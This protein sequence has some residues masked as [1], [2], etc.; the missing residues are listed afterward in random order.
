MPPGWTPAPERSHTLGL[1]K[2]ATD[3]DYE[4]ARAFC[5]QHPMEAPRLLSSD[6][7]DRV[8][9]EGC[10]VWTMEWPSSP[11]FV[12]HIQDGGEKGA[13]EV[14]KIV[15]DEKCKDVSLFSNLPILAG[16]YEIQGKTGVY[17]EVHVKK[18]AGIVAIG[19]RLLVPPRYR[20]ALM[21]A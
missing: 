19:T 10:K 14:T 6:V 17:Y 7:V 20:G 5:A 4:A 16:L 18:M 13:T 2:E 11:R 12:G 8:D 15:T 21:I 9:A 1:H 3:A